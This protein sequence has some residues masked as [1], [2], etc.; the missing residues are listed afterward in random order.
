[1]LDP[2]LIQGGEGIVYSLNPKIQRREHYNLIILIQTR[3][4]IN[5]VM[6][7]YVKYQ[8]PV[9]TRPVL[10]KRISQGPEGPEVHPRS[11]ATAEPQQH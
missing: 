5:T 9:R 2:R 4:K 11:Q 10:H 1:M 8:Q 3:S 7:N 6:A